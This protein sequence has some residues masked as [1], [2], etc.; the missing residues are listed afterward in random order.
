MF[1]ALVFMKKDILFRKRH[2]F[3]AIVYYQQTYGGKGQNT[4]KIVSDHI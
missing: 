2:I 4:N 3:Y 1:C